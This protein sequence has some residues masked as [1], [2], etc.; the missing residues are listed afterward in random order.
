MKQFTAYYSDPHFGHTRIID[1]CNR[2]FNSVHEMN[3][4]L[5]ERYNAV[6]G[7]GDHVLW[8]GDCFFG[9]LSFADKICRRLNGT[10]DLVLGNHDKFEMSGWARLGFE[11]AVESIG[12][13]VAGVVTIFTHRPMDV[14]LPTVS[15][16]GHR[17]SKTPITAQGTIDAGVD[18]WDYAPVSAER[19]HALIRQVSESR[20]P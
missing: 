18:A 6:V 1:Y 10:R 20:L 15:V 12:R 19:M 8:L 3:E 4:G 7:P 5:I 11:N 17:H 16:H 14:A 9:Q 2:P 13:V